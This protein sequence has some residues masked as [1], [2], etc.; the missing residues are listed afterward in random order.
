MDE[1]SSY[2]VEAILNSST[3]GIV[4][5]DEVGMIQQTNAAFNRFV[6]LEPDAAFGQPI[7]RYF[8][9][10]LHARIRHYVQEAL[11]RREIL[12]LE[13]TVIKKHL[14]NDVENF[15]DVIFYPIVTRK[16]QLSGIVCSLRD[17]TSYKQLQ[18]SLA[19]ARDKAL[20]AV[21]LKSE[22]LAMV[23][24]ELKTPLSSA[25]GMIEI[26]HDTSLDDEQTEMLLII[27]QRLQHLLKELNM[28]LDYSK[29]E[30][31]QMILATES[32]DL[33]EFIQSL[34]ET[35]HDIDEKKQVVTD[36]A[37]DIPQQV[38]GDAKRLQQLLVQI[39]DNAIKFTSEGDI[40]LQISSI[41]RTES[42]IRLRF[43]VED[44][45]I[46]IPQEKLEH[47]F[48]P[49]QQLDGSHKRKYEGIGLGL[50]LAKKIVDLMDGQLSIR[51]QP[52][53]GTKVVCDIAFDI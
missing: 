35:Y 21:R 48:N 39:L 28:I 30:A 38:R 50:S 34:L 31:E 33:R 24:H 16:N 19:S 2:I 14:E 4:L 49:F 32:F 8:P 25:L 53:K 9:D 44:R 23:S 18:E 51:S 37:L 42:S 27:E 47:L 5:L 3:D 13:S 6:Y 29:L 7:T 10:V 12:R 52:H 15:F 22:F 46:G 17:V 36:I 45:G 20:E 41:D 1:H 26:I 40:S 11:E 43:I